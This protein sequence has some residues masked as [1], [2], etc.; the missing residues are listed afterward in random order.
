MHMCPLAKINDGKNDILYMT[1][2][3]GS[4]ESVARLMLAMDNGE[5]FT[6]NGDLIPAHNNNYVKA[7][8]WTLDPTLK[9]SPPEGFQPE[10]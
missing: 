2:Q 9:A 4:R 1:D 5:Y 3:R 8:S 7:D 10:I 6:E